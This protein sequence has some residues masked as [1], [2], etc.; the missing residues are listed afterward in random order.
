MEEGEFPMPLT[1]TSTLVGFP[2]ANS[3]GVRDGV[4]LRQVGNM[5]VTTL[6]AIISGLEMEPCGLRRIMSRFA[7]AR[8][9][10]KVAGT[11]S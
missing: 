5:T 10:M 7:T 11:A 8:S 3:T 4:T 1:T 6:G 2:D 9:S